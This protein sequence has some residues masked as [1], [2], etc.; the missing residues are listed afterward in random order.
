MSH[1]PSRLNR[2]D[3]TLEVVPY[4][5]AWPARFEAERALLLAAVP[6]LF[7]SV[8]H[9]GSTAVPGLL[10]K[11]TIDMLAVSDDVNAVLQCVDALAG[12]GYDH[13]PGSF[14]DDDRHLFFR[15]VKE[16]KRLCHLHVVH[17]SSPEI[18]DY[19]LFRDFLRADPDAARRYAGL[20][21]GLVARYAD[22]RQAYVDAK[23][24]EV[25]VFMA[26]A[27][28]WRASRPRTGPGR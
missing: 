15:K 5:P 18:D 9:I 4:D 24:R 19:R 11:P 20:K 17:A 12:A 10:A 6:D 23:Q 7:L 27:R 13:R 8:E 3:G 2:P 28:R 25:D 22:R 21:L 16:G 1:L 14:P 26:E